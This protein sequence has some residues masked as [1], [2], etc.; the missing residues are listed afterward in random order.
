M[1]TLQC[2]LIR[3]GVSLCLLV[4]PA[5]ADTIQLGALSYDTFIPAGAGSP[6][7][8]A[9]DIANLTGAFSLAPDFPVADSLTLQAAV[10]TLTFSDASQ[11]IVNL[12]DIGPG[13]LLDG[14][15]NPLVQVPGDDVFASAELTATLSAL[16]F[17]LSNGSTFTAGTASIDTLLLPSSGNTLT[18]DVDQ[19][20]I[21]VS[22]PTVTTPEPASVCLMG[23][24]ALILILRLRSKAW[25][26]RKESA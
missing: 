17:M 14:S 10:L 9:F 20:I 16:R 25:C 18:V 15:G 11:Q 13:F 6:G 5:L 23:A 19:T 4:P 22:A 21:N 3:L 24:A 26:G 12:G 8:D 7:V 2:C 1:N